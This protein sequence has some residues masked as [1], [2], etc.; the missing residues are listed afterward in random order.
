[1]NTDYR[2]KLQRLVKAYDEHG[3]KW[4]NHH[5]QALFQAVEDTRTAL[6]QPEPVAPTDEAREL[7]ALLAVGSN[8]GGGAKLS[9]EQCRC[10]ATLLQQQARAVLTR[11]GTPTIQPAQVPAPATKEKI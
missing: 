8:C 3:G 6:A 4:R 7:V 5:E 10:A 11:W 2:A 9:P 1:M